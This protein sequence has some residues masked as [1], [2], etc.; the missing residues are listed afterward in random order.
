[1]EGQHP[2]KDLN[3]EPPKLCLYQPTKKIDA[4][5]APHISSALKD[6]GVIFDKSILSRSPILAGADRA[7]NSD[8]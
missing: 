2:E 1:M 8:S 3:L 6:L 7:G 5:I 4:N